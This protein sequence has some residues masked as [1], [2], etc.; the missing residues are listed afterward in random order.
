MTTSSSPPPPT[1]RRYRIL[2]ELGHGGTSDV[3]LAVAHGTAGFNKLVVLKALKRNIAEDRAS[4]RMFLA[5]ARLSARLNHPN[6]VQVNEVLEQDGVPVIVMEYLEGRAL[7]QILRHVWDRLPLRQHLRI[8]ADALRG[9]HYSHELCDYDGTPLNVVHRDVSPHNVFVT[10]DG[11]VKMLDFGLAKVG[12]ETDTQSGT[13]RGKLHYM[14][15]EQLAAERNL[16]RRADIYAVG[17]MLWEA[18][19]G[20]RLWADV[21]GPVVMNRV[22]SGD[23]PSPASVRADLPPRLER[24]CMRALAHDREARFP[25]AAAMGDELEA[26]LTELDSITD[27][28][29]LTQFMRRE[30]GELRQSMRR[31]VEEKLN[32]DPGAGSST[33][34]FLAGNETRSTRGVF[35]AA[36]KTITNLPPPRR[37]LP[38]YLVGAGIGVAALALG[39]VTGPRLWGDRA[40][41]PASTATLPPLASDLPGP[42]RVSLRVT[43]FPSSARIQLDGRELT[44]NPCTELFIPDDRLHTIRVEAPDHVGIERSVRLS[45]DIDL[46]LALKAAPK[47]SPS[48]KQPPGG[49]RLRPAEPRRALPTDDCQ[50]PYFIDSRGVKKYKRECL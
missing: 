48:T 1:D 7:S 16:D 41:P 39:L 14:A 19:A 25:S 6:V 30:F 12:S 32:E 10:Y 22:L 37:S 27:H 31:V 24:A 36:T 21:S 35:A 49:P 42:E 4:R 26:I 23:I 40:A 13:V 38:S 50:P 44:G 29:G 47:P 46:V 2:V 28:R 43:A 33:I 20:Q 34:R 45:S 11:S 3:Y 5:E 9:L 15:P 8:L 17:V 18:A